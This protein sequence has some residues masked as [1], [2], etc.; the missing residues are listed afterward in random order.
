MRATK[1][2]LK[3][4]T[5]GGNAGPAAQALNVPMARTACLRAVCL[6]A[7]EAGRQAG[8]VPDPEPSQG[9]TDPDPHGV[10]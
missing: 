4:D 2:A 10:K 7:V 8:Q 6:C 3:A 5:A 9:Q 1:L